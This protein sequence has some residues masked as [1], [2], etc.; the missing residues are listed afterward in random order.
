MHNER[1]GRKPVWSNVRYYLY[2]F[3]VEMRKIMED[4]EITDLLADF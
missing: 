2:F 3:L 4:L 1:R